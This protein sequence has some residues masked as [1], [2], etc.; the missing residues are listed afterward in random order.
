[1]PAA[2]YAG[3]FADGTL[4][5]TDIVV[6][7]LEAVVEQAQN[8]RGKSTAVVVLQVSGGVRVEVA[9]EKQAAMVAVLVQALAK[10]Y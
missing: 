3:F 5:F 9:D 7:W 1:M 10:S 8:P 4:E 6:Q 2:S